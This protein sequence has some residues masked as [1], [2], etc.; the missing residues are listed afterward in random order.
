MHFS[1]EKAATVKTWIVKKLEDMYVCACPYARLRG[2]VFRNPSRLR[3]TA[4]DLFLTYSSDA[5]SDVLADYVLALIRSEHSDEKAK[6]LC[7][8]NLQDFLQDS[9]STPCC[10]AHSSNTEGKWLMRQIPPG[11]W[12]MSSTGSPLNQPLRPSLP[13]HRSHLNPLLLLSRLLNPL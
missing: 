9:M 13:P 12:T 7:V 6:A 4:T 2:N 1:D 3:R 10:S 5:D 11:S 8:E